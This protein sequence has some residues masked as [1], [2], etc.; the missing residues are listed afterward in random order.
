MTV[1]W[2]PLEKVD[3]AGTQAVDPNLSGKHRF[4]AE[5]DAARVGSAM[6]QAD[7]AKLVHVHPDLIAKVEKATRWPTEALATVVTRRWTPAAVGSALSA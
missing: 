2:T 3:G 4:G 5:L 6:S 1:I 7:L